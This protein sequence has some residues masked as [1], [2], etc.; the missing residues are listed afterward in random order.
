MT[1]CGCSLCMTGRFG[2]FYNGID[3]NFFILY[4]S[5]NKLQIENDN[6]N[7]K[8]TI[9]MNIDIDIKSIRKNNETYN[10]LSSPAASIDRLS[11]LQ[12]I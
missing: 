12:Q 8:C 7:V 1:W 2:F 11:I 6:L 9:L 5:V 3:Y 4:T 10:P